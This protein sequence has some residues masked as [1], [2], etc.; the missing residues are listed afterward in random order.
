M[1][2]Q[3]RLF[4]RS[5]LPFLP[6]QSGLR[7]I[8]RHIVPFNK[9]NAEGVLD[10]CLKM[11]ESLKSEDIDLKSKTIFELG[12]GWEPLI[13]LLASCL[14]CKRVITVDLHRLLNI[15]SCKR[16]ADF[17]F[18]KRN[19]ISFRTGVKTVAIE[20]LI[21]KISFKNLDEFLKTSSIEYHSP[22]DA[23]NLPFKDNEIDLIVS[24][25][26]LEHIPPPIIEKIFHEFFR[27]LQDNGKMYHQIDNNDHWCYKD[28][29][30]T[31]V[32]FLKY[33]ER[34]WRL[35]EINPIDY[36]NR[37]RH[38]GYLKLLEKAGFKIRKDLSTLNEQ[39]LKI[40]DEMNLCSKYAPVSHDQLA[41]TLSRIIAEK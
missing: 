5:F 37:L 9:E 41:I 6:F 12:T 15:V 13:P 28:S 22:C 33:E 26:V 32:N 38:F 11:I 39:M 35:T 4:L 16:I 29:S 31:P 17:I 10:F 18:E 27:I 14:G 3:F 24:N 21:N 25:N 1:R 2:W 30:I 36:Q 23:R 7:S 19:L 20:N 8:K 40:L 34:R